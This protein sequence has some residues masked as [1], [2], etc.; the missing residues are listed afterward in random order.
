[1]ASRLKSIKKSQVRSS[2]K[3]T[4]MYFHNTLF[5]GKI[6]SREPCYDYLIEVII[7]SQIKE[8]K[9]KIKS[10]IYESTVSFMFVA[11]FFYFKIFIFFEHFFK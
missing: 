6:T 3:C 7:V 1:M 4:N 2:T 8:C 10:A 9:T 5:L 11:G